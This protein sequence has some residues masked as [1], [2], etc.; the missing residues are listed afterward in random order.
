[1]IR[2]DNEK[3]SGVNGFSG[4]ND[5]LYCKVL[6]GLVECHERVCDF[7][8]PSVDEDK[9]VKAVPREED[10]D[11]LIRL[12]CFCEDFAKDFKN[13]KFLQVYKDVHGE[14]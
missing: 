11:S 13:V 6:V 14:W 4:S 10:L 9:A 8:D 5:N 12:V 7:I 3:Y 2:C 1:M